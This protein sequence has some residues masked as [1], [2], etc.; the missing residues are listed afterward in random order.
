[1]GDGFSGFCCAW[2]DILIIQ[3]EILYNFLT[4]IVHKQKL[5][6]IYLIFNYELYLIL[7]YL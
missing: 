6:I 5:R 7:D 2:S 4:T 1:M 3:I